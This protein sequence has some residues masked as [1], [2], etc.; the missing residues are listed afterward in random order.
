MQHLAPECQPCGSG[1]L[2]EFLGRQIDVD[3]RLHSA[4]RRARQRQP[5]PHPRRERA[6]QCAKGGL[7]QSVL[8]VE[9]VRHESRRDPGAPRDL[10]ESR[11]DVA[12][13]GETVDRD[14]D[15]LHPPR[16][17]AF[18]PGGGAAVMHEVFGCG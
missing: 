14:L 18:I 12:D 6:R 7:E 8:V 11:A 1:T 9:V 15:Q 5:R 17:L 10:R 2:V 4:A 13:F 16:F 3:D